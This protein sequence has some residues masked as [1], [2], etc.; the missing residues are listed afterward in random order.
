M[1]RSLYLCYPASTARVIRVAFA[2][3]RIPCYSFTNGM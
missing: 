3:K 1:L 2:Q